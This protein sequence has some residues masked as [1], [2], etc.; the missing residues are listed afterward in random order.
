MAESPEEVLRALG[1]SLAV[2]DEADFEA[3][4]VDSG[5]CEA[6][7]MGTHVPGEVEVAFVPEAVLGAVRLEDVVVAGDFSFVAV[8]EL[9]ETGELNRLVA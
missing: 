7:L 1:D 9:S 2:H 8:H 6:A 4:D 3:G 5:T